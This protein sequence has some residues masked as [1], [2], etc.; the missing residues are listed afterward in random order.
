MIARGGVYELNRPG[1]DPLVG[2]VLSNDSW[3]SRMRMCVF[4]PLVA[5]HDAV[6]QDTSLSLGRSA[7]HWIPLNVPVSRLGVPSEPLARADLQAV[8]DALCQML[9]VTGLLGSTPR[10][11]RPVG[12]SFPHRG[13]VFYVGERVED[14]HKRY[15][16]VSPDEWNALGTS[17][18][19]VRT[20][21]SPKRPFSEFPVI[22][23]GVAQAC[24]GDLVAVAANQVAGADRPADN[25][26]LTR[27]DLIAIVRGVV[28]VLDLDVAVKRVLG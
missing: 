5:K 28:E 7:R 15:V 20:T 24:C 3:T 27:D 9:D 2:V 8:E 18:L 12:G 25:R 26:L 10:L 22:Q 11:R 16:V 19:M 21:T 1:S 14:E 6:D 23:G 13:E 17:V 4:V